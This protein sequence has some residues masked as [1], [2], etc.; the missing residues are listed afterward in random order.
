MTYAGNLMGRFM[1]REILGRE[2]LGREALGRCILLMGL[3]V[4]LSFGVGLGLGGGGMVQA[5]QKPTI[6]QLLQSDLQ[7]IPGQETILEV[8]TIPPGGATPR[9]VHPD[10][11]EIVY[12]LEGSTTAEVDGRETRSY[13]VGEVVHVPPNV[14]HIGRNASKTEPLKVLIIRIKDKSKPVMVPVK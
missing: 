9:H 7:G 14:P 11:H 10:G 1:G 5:Q 4:G 6:Q 2:T 8:L 3:A 12:V 13:G